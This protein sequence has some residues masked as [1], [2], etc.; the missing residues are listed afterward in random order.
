MMWSRLSFLSIRTWPS[1]TKITLE[2]NLQIWTNTFNS[3]RQDL[4]WMGDIKKK[5][6]PWHFLHSI[7]QPCTPNTKEQ[8]ITCSMCWQRWEVCLVHSISLVSSSQEYSVTTWCYRR[9]LGSFTTLSRGSSR[10]S[11]RRRKRSRRAS[12]QAT[13]RKVI[14]ANWWRIIER[15]LVKT[16]MRKMIERLP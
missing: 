1:P 7:S 8:F 5:E 14:T 16:Q 6:I 11:K 2:A 3:T 9:S 13:S 4:Q 12:K 10:R 15:D